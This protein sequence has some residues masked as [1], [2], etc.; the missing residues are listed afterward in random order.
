MI[1][2]LKLL[3]YLLNLLQM[4]GTVVK[5]T[6]KEI[7]HTHFPCGMGSSAFPLARGQLLEE[8]G[9][10]LTEHLEELER[11][12][13]ILLVIVEIACPAFFIPVR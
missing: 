1:P 8:G 11:E 3:L 2:L 7:I 9:A 13:G 5:M 4:G 6:E 12:E 10:E